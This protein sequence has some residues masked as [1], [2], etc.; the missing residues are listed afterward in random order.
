MKQPPQPAIWLLRRATWMSDT[1]ALTGDLVE[2]FHDERR[3]RSWF[4][5][6][7]LVAMGAGLA[8]AARRRWPELIYAL[9]ATVL[10]IALGGSVHAARSIL[11]WWAL[12]F[13]FSML[14]FDLTTPTILA[15]AAI[16]LL[17]TGLQIAGR[18]GWTSLLRTALIG[19]PFLAVRYY[20]T[21]F[22]LAPRLPAAAALQASTLALALLALIVTFV[23]LLVSALL[24][25]RVGPPAFSAS[26]RRQCS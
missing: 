5:R 15:L 4:W 11:P 20:V 16:P 1:E 26:S 12:P 18:F 21:A 6:Q 22:L 25:C 8:A 14:V 17:G 19:L 24:G 10:P 23:T 9:A 13:P 2:R 7:T 3:S